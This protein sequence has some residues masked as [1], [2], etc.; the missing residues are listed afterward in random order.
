MIA[1]VNDVQAKIA[2]AVEVDGVPPKDAE[3]YIARMDK[4]RS[5]Y[6][7]FF[8]GTRFGDYREYDLCLNSGHLGIDTCADV[9]LTALKGEAAP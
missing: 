6:Q 8:T 9:I 5:R 1:A 3:K 2:R 4:T 7:Q